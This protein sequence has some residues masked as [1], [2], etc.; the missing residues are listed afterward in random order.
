MAAL[1]TALVCR[2]S[3]SGMLSVMPAPLLKLVLSWRPHAS[4]F[5]EVVLVVI[6][7][8]RG[9]CGSPPWPS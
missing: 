8:F 2:L 1:L 6:L 9:H 4:V 7:A 5:N 3:E